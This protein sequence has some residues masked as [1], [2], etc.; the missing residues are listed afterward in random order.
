MEKMSE[1]KSKAISIVRNYMGDTTAQSYAGFY[2]TEDD[3]TIIESVRILLTE[4]VGKSQA[5][6]VMIQCGLIKK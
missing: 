1:V 3:A 4:Y 5:E 6:E 2:A